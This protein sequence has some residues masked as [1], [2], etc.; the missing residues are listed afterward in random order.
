MKSS[1]IR[2]FRKSDFQPLISM[3]YPFSKSYLLQKPS[4]LRIAFKILNRI[5]GKSDKKFTIVMEKDGNILGVL[6]YFNF[7]SN[8]W[9]TGPLFVS[10]EARGMGVGKKLVIAANQ[11]LV[12]MKIKKAYGDVPLNNP[13]RFLH[14]KLGCDFLDS[15]FTFEISKNNE[16]PS[17][18][19]LKHDTKFVTLTDRGLIFEKI[20]KCLSSKM[21][22]FFNI[23]ERNFHL[24]F[25]SELRKTSRI[26]FSK[27]KYLIYNDSVVLVNKLRFRPIWNFS[28]FL[29][30]T[31]DARFLFDKIKNYLD[32]QTI[33]GTLFFNQ[34]LKYEVI[35]NFLQVMN[36]SYN[37]NE[38]M[39]YHF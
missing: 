20:R 4:I 28:I 2:E 3:G 38:I 29:N 21:Q 31:K 37:L 24:P 25:E 5:L 23:S 6:T 39:I 14:S 22:D 19:L 30:D 8:I 9:I 27:V 17:P 18:E 13:S 34:N 15:F 1:I 26:F 11:I 7:D 16:I 33:K 35:E 10:P 36:V 32:N 12:N